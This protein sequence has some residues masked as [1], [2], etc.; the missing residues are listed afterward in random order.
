MGWG[1][2]GLARNDSRHRR[3]VRPRGYGKDLSELLGSGI[4][5]E[6]IHGIWLR[7]DTLPNSTSMGDASGRPDTKRWRWY[8]G[9]VL[10]R[11]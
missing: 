10:C 5:T 2:I 8:G 11:L 1:S 6:F 9:V 3:S 7:R 4:R